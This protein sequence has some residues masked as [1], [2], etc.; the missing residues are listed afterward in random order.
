VGL[1]ANGHLKTRFKVVH[2][3]LTQSSK[4]LLYQ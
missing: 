3:H 1:L 4:S 2:L